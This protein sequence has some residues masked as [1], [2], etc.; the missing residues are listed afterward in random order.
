MEGNLFELPVRQ[1]R[2]AAVIAYDETDAAADLL[3]IESKHSLY[4]FVVCF[5]QR[6]YL[7]GRDDDDP[8]AKP[9]INRSKINDCVFEDECLENSG[10]V[11][12]GERGGCSSGGYQREGKG[13]PGL[14]P[15]S[16]VSESQYGSCAGNGA[17][18]LWHSP[19]CALNAVRIV[20]RG[21]RQRER[22]NLNIG[23]TYGAL[24][25]GGS[26]FALGADRP[27]GAFTAFAAQ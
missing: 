14:T 20:E 17:R 2:Q 27:G 26:L 8:N 25:P 21:A 5:S 11:R 4:G 24:R 3:A 22:D 23:I 10:A 1:P 6:G 13:E 15:G 18:Q 9:C 7:A 16:D 12:I 19:R